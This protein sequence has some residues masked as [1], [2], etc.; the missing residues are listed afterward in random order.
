MGREKPTSGKLANWS[1]NTSTKRAS[2]LGA[3]GYST[4]NWQKCLI[5]SRVSGV[6]SS[7]RQ[8]SG[9][10]AESSWRTYRL[11][12][13]ARIEVTTSC[14]T[15]AGIQMPHCGGAKKLPSA[16]CTP[17]TPLMA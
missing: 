9:A 7:T 8:R 15:P 3:S 6:T 16:V 4:G 1:S 14:S 17:S 2:G 12:I 11:R 5:N 13:C 10:Q